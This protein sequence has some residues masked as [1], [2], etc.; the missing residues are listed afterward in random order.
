MSKFLTL[1]NRN[2]E[3]YEAG[4]QPMDQEYIKLNANE[5][6]RPPS[7]EVLKALQSEK[8]KSL[9]FYVN[10]NLMDL[11]QAIADRFQ[12]KPEQ[13]CA[14]NGSDEMLAFIFL[15]FFDENTEIAYPDIT[16][17]F[18]RVI[19][20]LYGAKGR[21]I[22]LKEDLAID[23][24]AFIDSG[25]HIVLA[26]PNNPT[27]QVL[28]VA[29]IERM[30]AADSNRLV[31]I[32]E[33]YVD[34][35]NESCIPLIAKYSNLIVVHTMSKSKNLAGAHIGYAMAD[36]SIISD[37]ENV[38]NSFNPF[39]LN[40]MAIDVGIAAINDIQYYK[41]CASEV[42][43]LR[44]YL[45]QELVKMK[46]YVVDTHTNFVFV[47]HPNLSGKEYNKQLR[48]DGILA[49][50]FENPRISNFL[51]I[52]IGTKEEVEAVLASTKRILQ[53]LV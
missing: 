39:N 28:S 22:P 25:C 32:D 51:R 33:A 19:T 5:T 44:E 9:G 43:E 12:L 42:I 35:G 2:I 23:A 50:Y 52:T 17:S 41:K 34:Y 1:K 53:Q 40:K 15:A 27:G 6:S 18:Y 46:F 3:P 30:A 47:S 14:G 24:D 31:I 26:N 21:T 10:P 7:P 13:V 16:Y 8:M 37:I 11:R 49:R 45:K 38:K 20:K 29:E 4:E 48:E 36:E